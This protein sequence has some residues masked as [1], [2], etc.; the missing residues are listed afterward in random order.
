[1]SLKKELFLGGKMGAGLAVMD[2][3]AS[4]F[5]ES[6]STQDQADIVRASIVGVIGTTIF[7]KA[8][9]ESA[10]NVDSNVKQSAFEKMRSHDLVVLEDFR[11]N[12]NKSTE[13]GQRKLR[14]G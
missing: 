5:L 8:L 12:R 7:L 9:L 10:K 11:R 14:T 2:L 13:S 4:S 3:S 6:I 1:M